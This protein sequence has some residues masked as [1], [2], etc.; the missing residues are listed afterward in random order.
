MP[1]EMSFYGQDPYQTIMSGHTD[2]VKVM[3]SAENGDILATGGADGTLR[4]WSLLPGYGGER[5][6]L[7]KHR[8][9]IN[10]IAWSPNEQRLVS[11]DDEGHIWTL[12]AEKP[13][14]LEEAKE[15]A[16]RI[17]RHREQYPRVKE[18][19]SEQQEQT[20]F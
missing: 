5:Q 6:H 19:C 12:K 2:V 1:E 10:S 8:E 9:R 18:I 17:L 14:D 13:K 20:Q 11:G 7:E 16:C 15:W 3:A 4:I